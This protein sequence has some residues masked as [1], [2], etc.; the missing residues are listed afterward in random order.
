MKVLKG[1][2]LTLD[3]GKILVPTNGTRARIKSILDKINSAGSRRVSFPRHSSR[4]SRRIAPIS[5]PFSGNFRSVT[6]FR[7]IHVRIVL[8][9]RVRES[10]IFAKTRKKLTRAAT[11]PHGPRSYRFYPLNVYPISSL[12]ISTV[13][14][15]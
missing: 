1:P 2:Q 14:R 6:S 9:R 7:S 5:F 4:D 3:S 8:P 15:V 12:K 13:N 11:V 10:S